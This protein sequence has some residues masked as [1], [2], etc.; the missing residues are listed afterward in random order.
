MSKKLVSRKKSK[1]SFNPK[2]IS[3]GLSDALKRDLERPLH[4]SGETPVSSFYRDA[5]NG[6][7]LSK[8]SSSDADSSTLEKESFDKFLQMNSHMRTINEHFRSSIDSPVAINNGSVYDLDLV[9]RRAK[10]LVKFVLTPL[11]EDEY[12]L[13]CKSSGGSSIGVPYSNTSPE[14][15]YTYPLSVSDKKLKPLW[16]RYKQFHPEFAKALLEL[17]S[18]TILGD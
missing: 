10:A 6:K 18:D 17:N 14:R 8:F 15:K 11:D 13:G 4:V 5:Q 9:L 7:F 1:R 3:I 2:I 16:Q 12:F